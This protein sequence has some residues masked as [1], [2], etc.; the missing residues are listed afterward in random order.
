MHYL[1]NQKIENL[2]GLLAENVTTSVHKPLLYVIESI[3]VDFFIQETSCKD[4]GCFII[5]L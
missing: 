1:L 2:G 4:F 3:T 5:L